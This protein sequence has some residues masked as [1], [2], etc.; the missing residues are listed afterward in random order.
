MYPF[1]PP[2]YGTRDVLLIAGI[3][4]LLL[5]AWASWLLR[6]K[7][8]A[9]NWD[10]AVWA[11]GS[12]FVIFCVGVFTLALYRYLKVGN[13]PYALL[14]ELILSALV[15]LALLVRVWRQKAGLWMAF[16]NLIPLA[17]FYLWLFSPSMIHPMEAA[18][19]SQCKNNLKQ[20]GLAMHNYND[21][22]RTFPLHAGGA[23][24][25]SWRVELLP[26]HEQK[27]LYESYRQSEAWDSPQNR[28]IGQTLVPNYICPTAKLLQGVSDETGA[29]WTSYAVAVG[30]EAI[31]EANRT[32]TMREI[33]DG[34][35]NTIMV[36]E[37]CGQRIVWTEPRDLPLASTPLGINLPGPAEF[38]SDGLM[39]S[40]HRGSTQVLLA[41]GSAR[42]LS[43]E[44]SP[45]VLKQM[46][47]VND[48]APEEF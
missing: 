6:P 38:Q 16:V 8:K 12:N 29:V 48:G 36:V 4:G 22:Y 11:M 13:L 34:S 23:P 9:S 45:E 47:Q 35:S 43:D 33:P 26:Y 24:P 42:W 2:V 15:T 46:L 1:P 21:V 17:V 37:A 28:I 41:D 31:F 27:A 18:R 39:S 30:A 7:R 40:Y 3:P 20:I 14:V 5:A 44:T 32:R 10:P 19:R 25:R